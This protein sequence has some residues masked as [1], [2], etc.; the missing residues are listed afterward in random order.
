MKEKRSRNTLPQVLQIT[1]GTYFSSDI[2][3]NLAQLS[4]LQIHNLVS[5]WS[6][7]VV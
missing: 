5:Q 4:E 6:L 3:M 7:V 2:S 1:Y